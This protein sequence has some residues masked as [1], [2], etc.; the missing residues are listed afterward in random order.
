MCTSE[1]SLL[2]VLIPVKQLSDLE[3]SFV[4]RVRDHLFRL[5]VPEK[6]VEAEVAQMNPI[7]IG[8]T[9]SRSVLGS[10]RDFAI[11]A[12][13]QFEYR[14]Q[15]VSETEMI[16]AETPCGPLKYEFPKDVAIERLSYWSRVHL[17]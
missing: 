1:I 5:G 8:K 10:M 16:L 14:G 7:I 12:K 6:A 11:G 2:C 17:H 13:A 3:A 15:N 9:Q 4:R